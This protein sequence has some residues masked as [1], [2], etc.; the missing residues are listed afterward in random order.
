MEK[1]LLILFFLIILWFG[2]QKYWPK[3]NTSLQNNLKSVSFGKTLLQVEIAVS[4][5]EITRGLSGRKELP[6][7]SGMLFEF[8]SPGYYSFWMKDMRFPIDIIW[9]DQYK[10]VIGFSEN[11]Q[12]ESFPN[13]YSPPSP[14][15]FV[16]EV[17]SG[18]VRN[19]NIKMGDSV[20]W[21][22]N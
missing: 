14:V 5:A 22:G 17:N 18:W 2:W 19:N 21:L 10:K 6:E 12:P 4:N 7:S 8:N 11:L 13:K 15:Q 20:N 3:M 9:I 1:S 16:I